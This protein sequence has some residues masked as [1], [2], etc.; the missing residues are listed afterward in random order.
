[1]IFKDQYNVSFGPKLAF[2]SC[3]LATVAISIW[4]MFAGLTYSDTGLKPYQISGDFTRRVLIALCLI[5]YFIRLQIT[6]WVFL[7]RKWAWLEA[8]IISIVMPLVLYS[9][10]YV[11]GNNHQ[12]IGAMEIVGGLLYITG[13]YPRRGRNWPGRSRCRYS[14]G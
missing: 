7:K 9:F 3:M 2:S 10:A 4:L 14:S 6:V 5:I 8:I 12:S 1:M 11:G 13:S